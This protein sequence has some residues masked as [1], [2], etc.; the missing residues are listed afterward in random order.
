[1]NEIVHFLFIDQT[2]S[3]QQKISPNLQLLCQLTITNP[4]TSILHELKQVVA[5]RA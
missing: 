5:T 4:A 1:M 3:A 2:L